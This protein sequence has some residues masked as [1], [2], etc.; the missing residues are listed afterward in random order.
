MLCL[1][2]GGIRRIQWIPPKCRSAYMSL[3]AYMSHAPWNRIRPFFVRLNFQAL[4]VARSDGDSAYMP[5]R[6]VATLRNSAS[7]GVQLSSQAC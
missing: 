2:V 1:S 4:Y 7:P 5:H 3:S 6:E